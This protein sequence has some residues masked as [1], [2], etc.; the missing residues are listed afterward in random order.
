MRHEKRDHQQ[1]ERRKPQPPTGRA[2]RCQQRDC[3]GCLTG[4]NGD[5]ATAH[6]LRPMCGLYRHV[7]VKRE[8]VNAVPAQRRQTQRNIRRPPR[9]C[10]YHHI[11]R[12]L[13]HGR[14]LHTGAGGFNPLCAALSTKLG[15]FFL[16]RRLCHGSLRR[17]TMMTARV[18][19]LVLP[20][21]G[22]VGAV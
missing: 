15:G 3:L 7:M 2:D 19:L 4:G 8:C 1:R 21:G 13:V 10:D 14:R 18:I 22:V 12:H 20:L 6:G 17:V 9:G 5:P 16:P 11:R